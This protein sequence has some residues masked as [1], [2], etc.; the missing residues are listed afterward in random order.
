MNDYEGNGMTRKS[1]YL[2]VAG[3]AVIMAGAITASVLAGEGEDRV[4]TSYRIVEKKTET[5]AP[6]YQPLEKKDECVISQ[7]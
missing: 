7:R 6:A 2:T 4:R 5:P 3:C 1:L